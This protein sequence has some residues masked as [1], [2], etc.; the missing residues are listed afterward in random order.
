MASS[1]VKLYVGCA[2]THSSA[3]FKEAIA[4]LKTSLRVQGYEILD[5]FGVVDGDPEAVYRRDIVHCVRDCDG[6]IA[7]CDHPST[8]LGFELG[9]ATRLKKHILALA[10]NDAKVTRL[11]QGA[12]IVEE[13]FSFKR[14]QDFSK[15]APKLIKN[16]ITSWAT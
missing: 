14:Y 2:L 9:E 4:Q 1:E 11:V 16:W 10:Q 8:G 7:I 13:N 12:A 3:E 15:D 6:F 5:F